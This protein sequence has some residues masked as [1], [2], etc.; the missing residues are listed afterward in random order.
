MTSHAST[1]HRRTSSPQTLP[2]DD[3]L[4]SVSTV[5]SCA[6]GKM[7]IIPLKLSKAVRNEENMNVSPRSLVPRSNTAIEQSIADSHMALIRAEREVDILR[8]EIYSV[9]GDL[10]TA[11]EGI[12][13]ER[14]EKAKLVE[15]LTAEREQLREEY[16]RRYRELHEQLTVLR[17]LND[18]ATEDRTHLV[19]E[20]ESRKRHLMSFVDNERREK[21]QLL[22]EY[23][24]GT[25]VL[26]CEQAK[27][28]EGLRV[29]LD[30]ANARELSFSTELYD[31]QQRR[32]ELESAV[33]KWETQLVDERTMHQKKTS[34]RE[35]ASALE[36]STLQDV[37]ERSER[38][39]RGIIEKL[40]ETKDQ[41]QESLRHTTAQ[42]ESER[43]T[44]GSEREEVRRMHEHE[45][46]NT[47][48]ELRDM[49]VWRE[50][51]EEQ[52]HTE[53]EKITQESEELVSSLRKELDTIR[54]Q[55]QDSF[56]QSRHAKESMMSEHQSRLQQMQVLQDTLR[57][58]LGEERQVKKDI[59]SARQ[60]VVMKLDQ[61]Q[62]EIHRLHSEAE[63]A[64]IE[65]RQVERQREQEH[66]LALETVKSQVRTLESEQLHARSQMRKMEDEVRHC[67]NQNENKENELTS[68]RLEHRAII[69]EA[70]QTVTT[71]TGQLEEL[72]MSSSR[73]LDAAQTRRLE[74]EA[75]VTRLQRFV[76]ELNRKLTVATNHLSAD[77]H[78]VESL[79][80]ELARTRTSLELGNTSHQKSLSLLAEKESELDVLRHKADNVDKRVCEQ[81]DQ[82]SSIIRGLTE[83][84]R[85][86]DEKVKDT[87]KKSEAK[88]DQFQA[89]ILAARGQISARE[90]TIEELERVVQDH[91]DVISQ[92][93]A[94]MHD[95]DL[96]A[97]HRIETSER[98]YND[99]LGR[100]ES[101]LHGLKEDVNKA[102]KTR[103]AVQGEA[104]ERVRE[105]ES[106]VYRLQESV[107]TER[108]SR[109]R[110]TDDLR[111]KENTHVEQQ[112]TIRMLT[113]R[114][115][116]RQ[117]EMR[118]ME[119]EQQTTLYKYQESSVEL[120]RKDLQLHQMMARLRVLEIRPQPSPAKGPFISR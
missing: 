100:M 14:D 66:Q 51:M 67:A 69:D 103:Y 101:V 26:L 94:T 25:E 87:L 31:M 27:E 6:Q 41:L 59:E 74:L 72:R 82:L 75:E 93:K 80:E 19:E 117:E 91:R 79:S 56:D 32:V 83:D 108:A 70:R 85:N 107:E 111:V 44:Y 34:D 7:N 49:K 10:R 21:A 46:E 28:I 38:E 104:T 78:Q 99:D 16:E 33:L 92:M 50:K 119:T 54:Q 112:G 8:E 57:R 114:L 13:R 39:L 81:S 118:K 90:S 61:S 43:M 15:N 73:S 53:I 68:Q 5:V 64:Q 95:K 76:E 60:T 47:V 18:S 23:R 48:R 22:D 96:E 17:G 109:V 106:H 86:K 30:T 3:M 2:S 58:E 52:S 55:K 20:N 120:G 77:R 89:E 36:I 63:H 113:T 71:V 62:A 115:Q 9:S 24:S 102:N 97:Q 105:L 42:L 37:K 116:A 65:G 110:L 40:M 84:I 1:A 98:R 4:S 12:D 88:E 29:L 45:L 35:A 11:R